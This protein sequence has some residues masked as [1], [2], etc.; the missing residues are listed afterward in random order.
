VGGSYGTQAMPV[1]PAPSPAA[2]FVARAP[3]PQLAPAPFVAPA[4]DHASA[5]AHAV[6]AVSVLAD[7]FAAPAAP[8]PSKPAPEPP[9]PPRPAEA[10][11][12]LV[13]APAADVP[14]PGAMFPPPAPIPAGPSS[15]E[16]SA[17]IPRQ[18]S[19]MHPMAY[20]FIA[21]AAVFGGVAAY[22]LVF[23][24]PTERIVERTVVKTVQA[25]GEPA[26]AGAAPNETQAPDA[27]AAPSG[28][29]AAGPGGGRVRS[30][31]PATPTATPP[32]PGGAPI[33]TSGF[34]N[35]GVGGPSAGNAPSPGGGGQLSQG[36]I[37]GVV[38]SNQAR[39]RRQC[40][41][42]ALAAK[43]P[44]AP[45]SVKVTGT[46]TIGPSGN[47]ESANASGGDSYPG[48]ASCIASKMKNWKFPPSNGSQTVAVPFVFAG[49]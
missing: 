39:I 21:M 12:P 28:K 6:K 40:W 45:N 18:R 47:V 4:P 3:E 13:P 38:S 8:G 41:E 43:S 2:P 23:K 31:A 27:T 29:V 35:G 42:Q 26:P 37:Q 11:N 33:D 5:P 34:S 10:L 32:A 20:A 15:A 30:S 14:P 44:N 46:M 19:G 1:A 48:L 16:L 24:P 25:P 17:L 22:I 49:Q 36:E 7:P 9:E